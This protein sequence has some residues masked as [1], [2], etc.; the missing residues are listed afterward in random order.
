MDIK[1]DSYN[2]GP[3]Q[4]ENFCH[5]NL[6]G[7]FLSPFSIARASGR[8]PESQKILKIA[9]KPRFSEVHQISKML[10]NKGGLIHKFTW[11]C[12]LSGSE[13][14]RNKGGNNSPN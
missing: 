7:M 6:S 14:L 9:A 1:Y 2:I 3:P 12:H 4:A 11:T 13:M 10:R 5:K 8:C